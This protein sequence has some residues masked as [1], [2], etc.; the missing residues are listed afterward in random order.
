MIFH[1]LVY[2]ASCRAERISQLIRPLESV[3]DDSIGCALWFASR[4][5]G[6]VTDSV[7][8]KRPYTSK[9]RVVLSGLGADEQLG[10]YSRLATDCIYVCL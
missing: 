9:A 1:A 5:S 6:V 3:L 7:G 10:G 2:L 4:G 8:V